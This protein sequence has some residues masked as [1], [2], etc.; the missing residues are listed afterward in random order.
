[1]AFPIVPGPERQTLHAILLN[2]RKRDLTCQTTGETMTGSNNE[3]RADD[4]FLRQKSPVRRLQ[5]GIA[6]GRREPKTV[7]DECY[8]RSKALL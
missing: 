7:E 6:A 3:W 2:C 8:P 5:P 4:C 1:M